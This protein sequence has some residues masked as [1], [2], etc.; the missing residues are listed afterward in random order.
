MGDAYSTAA[1]VEAELRQFIRY[2][3]F[4]LFSLI[5]II[6]FMIPSWYSLSLLACHNVS[7]RFAVDWCRLFPTIEGSPRS[8]HVRG[9]GNNCI[10]EMQ[11]RRCQWIFL[12]P[13][14]GSGILQERSISKKNSSLRDAN[15][16][17]WPPIVKLI[18]TFWFSFSLFCQCPIDQCTSRPLFQ[19]LFIEVKRRARKSRIGG[20]RYIK[21]LKSRKCTEVNWWLFCK[22]NFLLSVPFYASKSRR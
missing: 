2:M 22:C 12:E 10:W 20:P 11:A 7:F 4:R 15:S 13:P 16:L 21:V 14:K 17:A 3:E 18:Y 6:I 1:L 9:H 5:S 19:I 8:E